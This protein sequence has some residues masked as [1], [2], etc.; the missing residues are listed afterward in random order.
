MSATTDQALMQAVRDGEIDKLGILFERYHVMLFNFLLGLT[1]DRNLS[2]DLVQEVFARMLKYRHT[3]KAKSQFTTWMF[4]IARNARIDHYR[5]YAP[6][7]NMANTDDVEDRI[8]A[9]ENPGNQLEE[10]QETL[11]LQAALERLPEDK[12][13]VLLLSRYEDMKYEQVAE[14]LNCSVGTVK[15][16]VF[17]AMQDL[18]K[19]FLELTG[20]KVS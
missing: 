18:R 15:T 1:R 8:I 19:N 5:K 2:E 6:E 16:R 14:I 11:F 7:E 9:T 13:E 4:Q 12:R 3:Y 10:E 17:R 20:E